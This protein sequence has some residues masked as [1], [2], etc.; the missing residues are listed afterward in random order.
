M[1]LPPEFTTYTSALFGPLRWQRFLQAFEE[2]APVSI[3][4]N[5]WKVPPEPIFPQATAVPWCR[6]AYWLDKRPDFT[7]DP[8][9]HAGIYYVQEAGSLFLD[10]VLRQFVTVPV[11]A[12][13]LCGAPGGKST[14]MRAALPAGSLLVSNEPD[15][16]RANILLENMLKQG[17]PDVLVTHNY[18]HDFQKTDWTFDVILTDVP[19]SGEGLFRRDAGAV[20]EWSLQN[21]RFCQERQRQILQD[22]WPCLRP[23]GLLIYSTCTFNTHENEENVRFIAQK[24]GAEVLSI[25]VPSQWQITGSLLADW[26]DPVY[27]FIPGITQS[28]GLFIA[29]LRKKGTSP[30]PAMLPGSVRKHAQAHRLIH[31]LSDGLPTFEQKGKEKIPSVAQALSLNTS[32]DAYP[33]VELTL[34]QARRYLH[35]ESFVLPANAPKGFVL[36]TYQNCPLGFMKN[37]GERANNLYPKNWAIRHL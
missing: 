26:N 24:L 11:L 17:H 22:I 25:P 2:T 21:V 7:L 36:V 12:L 33:R 13:D 32:S 35:R 5:P 18:A 9:F 15:R 3:R 29:V 6:H 1:S 4:L 23:G 30:I 10:Y 16:R 19:C 37:L 8:L 28:E 20:S 34:E 14:L 27:R 31:V